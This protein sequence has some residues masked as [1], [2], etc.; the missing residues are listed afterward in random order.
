MPPFFSTKIRYSIRIASTNTE[1]YEMSAKTAKVRKSGCTTSGAI[2]TQVL[3]AD[4]L[5][6]STLMPL[7]AVENLF[8]ISGNTVWRWS[9]TG[10]LKPIRIGH[11]TRWRLGELRATIL[12]GA[13]L[14]SRKKTRP[15]RKTIVKA[16]PSQSASL[17]QDAGGNHALS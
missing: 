17:N 14:E 11:T 15:P 5:P 10:I 3:N 7:P 9:R 4:H 6:D 1:R 13:K 8:G 16:T 12:D 2:P